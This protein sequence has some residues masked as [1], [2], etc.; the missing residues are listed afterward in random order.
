MSWRV[1]T[2]VSRACPPRPRCHPAIALALSWPPTTCG[3]GGNGSEPPP[4]LGSLSSPIRL[5][6]NRKPRSINGRSW[7][8]VE[9]RESFMEIIDVKSR[10]VVAV[11]EVL[12][13]ANK[14]PESSGRK[15]FEDKRRVVMNSTIHRVEID[16]LRGNRLVHVP[17]KPDS[18]EYVVH[19]SKEDERPRCRLYPIRLS[20]RLPVV[21]IPL[22]PEDSDARLD[23]QAVLDAA[24]DRAGFRPPN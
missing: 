10:D 7:F 18:Y 15:S 20:Q 11:I 6:P 14:V 16:L 19:V 22:K 12:S 8:E 13:P 23:L 3:C 17:K 24:F 21:P 9:I 2:G 1:S 5:R 4:V